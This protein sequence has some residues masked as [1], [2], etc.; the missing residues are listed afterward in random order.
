VF[1]RLEERLINVDVLSDNSYREAVTAIAKGCALRGYPGNRGWK[2]RKPK[3]GCD[4]ASAAKTGTDTTP[5]G[6]LLLDSFL[7][8]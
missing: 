3:R 4:G 7:P 5:L 1:D 6:L 2:D 8:G